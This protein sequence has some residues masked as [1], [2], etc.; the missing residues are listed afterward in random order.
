M[1]VPHPTK[2]TR[3]PLNRE[4][5]LK[6]VLEQA[7]RT[8]ATASEAYVASQAELQ[9]AREGY[10]SARR[11]HPH[12][13]SERRVAGLRWSAAEDEAARVSAAYA[14]ATKGVERARQAVA[15]FRP[16]TRS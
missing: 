10:E 9:Q 8:F 2:R 11:D 1:S 12:G 16:D 13:S 7:E 5:R 6:Q 4:A 14:S 15:M 3:V